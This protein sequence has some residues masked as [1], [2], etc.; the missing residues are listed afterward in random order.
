MV[1]FKIILNSKL[2]SLSILIRIYSRQTIF[3]FYFLDLIVDAP[4][5]MNAIL[6]QRLHNAAVVFVAEQ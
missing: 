6:R 3:N 1:N 2:V 5:A 4:C